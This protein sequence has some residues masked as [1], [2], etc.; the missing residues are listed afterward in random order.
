ME[1]IKILSHS[2]DMVF[3]Q[4]EKKRTKALNIARYYVYAP[5]YL[6]KNSQSSNEFS[7]FPSEAVWTELS[8]DQKQQKKGTYFEL[9]TFHTLNLFLE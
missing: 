9:H 5:S 4:I 7:L 3:P 6:K 8:F 1:P 2:R